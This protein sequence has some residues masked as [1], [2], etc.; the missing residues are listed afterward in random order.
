MNTSNPAVS[1]GTNEDKT[2][3]IVSYLT[4]IGFIAAVVI[5][6]SKKTHLGAY[7]LRQSLGLMLAS[8]AL[9]IL[10]MVFAFIPVIGLIVDLGLWF[11][12]LALWLIGLITAA[13][14]EQKPLPVVG[15]QF[16]KWFGNAFQ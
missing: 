9:M 3:A 7:H 8:I 4:L 16:E 5:H 1:V 15:P 14:G 12:L 10:G 13:R 2:T 6:G 11:S